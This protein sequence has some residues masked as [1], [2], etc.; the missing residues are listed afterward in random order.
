MARVQDLLCTISI[1]AYVAAD[2]PFDVVGRPA[3]CRRCGNEECFH[4]HG[5]YPRYIRDTRQKVARFLC[6]HCRLT[7]SVL[8]AGVL[9]YKARTLAEADGYF[10]AS[11]AVRPNR[12]WAEML[13]RYWRQWFAYWAVLQ[14]LSG[15]PPGRSPVRE[16]RAYW[17]QL[18]DWRELA[19]TQAE[20]VSRFG[21]S[22][23]RRYACHQVPELRLK[24]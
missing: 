1:E 16:P 5:T 6:R 11:D 24:C 4:R 20:L 15:W 3:R 21:L 10:R 2:N 18:G 9:P 22:L 17:Q 23:L 19:V 8:P 14:H 7:V 13:R 12:S